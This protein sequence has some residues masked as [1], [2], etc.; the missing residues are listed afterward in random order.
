MAHW[1][2][3]VGQGSEETDDTYPF[4]AYGT[5]WLAFGQIRIALFF[6]PAFRDP[7]RHRGVYVVGV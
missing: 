3:L 6:L 4:I 2:L 1:V 7:V 5:D